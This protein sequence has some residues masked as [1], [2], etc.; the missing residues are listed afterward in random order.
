[1]VRYY[2]II[3]LTHSPQLH[4]SGVPLPPVQGGGTQHETGTSP[5]W[6]PHCH[7]PGEH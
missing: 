7:D 1:M 2:K 5:V 6:A 3:T 4:S